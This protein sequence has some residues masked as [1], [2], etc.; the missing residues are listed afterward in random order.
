MNACMNVVS[1][2]LGLLAWGLSISAIFLLAKKKTTQGIYC[3]FGSF[4][5]ALISLL[6]VMFYRNFLI[7]V[8]D[9][10]ALADT[11][12]GFLFAA[13]VMTGLAAGM[14]GLALA[15]MARHKR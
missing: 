8:G 6:L 14:N 3:V 12:G 7:A 2:V 4:V 5:C 11:A 10:S 9:W 1:I 13:I 15:V